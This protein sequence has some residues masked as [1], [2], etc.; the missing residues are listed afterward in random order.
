MFIV[1]TPAVTRDRLRLMARPTEDIEVIL[2][3]YRTDASKIED[4]DQIEF[5]LT[6]TDD[7][8]TPD[9]GIK[10]HSLPMVDDAKIK[11]FDAKSR[12]LFERMKNDLQGT[13]TEEKMISRSVEQINSLV[14]KMNNKDLA[15]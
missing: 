1:L 10:V 7:M 14:E 6:L 11:A 2:E 3:A 5:C 9:S 12:N 4:P 8:L 15:A 13:L